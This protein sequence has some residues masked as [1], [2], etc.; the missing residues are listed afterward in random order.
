MAAGA[1]FAC[2][3]DPSASSDDMASIS[4]RAWIVSIPTWPSLWNRLMGVWREPDGRDELDDQLD[5]EAM[6]ARFA[7][8]LSEPLSAYLA[9][10]SGRPRVKAGS[11]PRVLALPMRLTERILARQGQPQ[12][13]RC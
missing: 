6:V 4:T 3:S 13:S 8:E 5:A 10:L 7:V 11:L 12:R 1:P 2:R 9:A